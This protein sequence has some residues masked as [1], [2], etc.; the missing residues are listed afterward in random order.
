MAVDKSEHYVRSASSKAHSDAPL[1]VFVLGI[2]NS[3]STDL[4][5]L[6]ADAGNGEWLHATTADSILSKCATLVGAGRSFV[7]KDVTIDWGYPTELTQHD[8]PDAEVRLLMDDQ[9]L[10]Q[11]PPTITKLYPGLRLRVFALITGLKG[12]VDLPRNVIIR[13]QRD[14][15]GE[16]YTFPVPVEQVKFE[17]ENSRVHLMHTLAA[18]RMIADLERLERAQQISEAQ[19]KQATVRFGEQY[20]LASRYTS[21]VAVEEIDDPRFSVIS[22]SLQAVRHRRI[23]KYTLRD[24]RPQNFQQARSPSNSFWMAAS[25]YA[26]I[27]K[28]AL[29]QTWLRTTPP[30]RTSMYDRR[31]SLRVMPGDWDAAIDDEISDANDEDISVADDAASIAS[32]E[33]FD[34]MSSLIS[35]ESCSSLWTSRTPSPAL[36][37]H[38]RSPSPD[39]DVPD[40]DPSSSQRPPTPPP[41][42]LSGEVDQFISLLSFDG[43]WSTGPQFE[44]IVGKAAVEE[45]RKFPVK[46][47]LWSTALAIAYLQKHMRAHPQLLAIFRDKVDEYVAEHAKDSSIAFKDLVKEA[48]K[49][50]SP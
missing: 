32:E 36:D 13:A 47:V 21:F 30:S 49:V 25:D 31:T 35:T 28:D 17:R 5:K 24:M 43:S 3:V 6:L 23:S 19:S 9:T 40:Y 29:M 14:V 10:Q 50:L 46:P 39:I 11:A 1:R 15:D 38:A 22:N 42:P 20:G 8:H 2:G 45:G 33:S 7:V 12:P 37:E 44:H 27:L 16:E 26:V 18:R 4:C 41:K 34:T 48:K